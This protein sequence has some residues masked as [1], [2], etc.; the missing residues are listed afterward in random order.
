MTVCLVI[1]TLP[2]GGFIRLPLI[3]VPQQE[4]CEGLLLTLIKGFRSSRDAHCFPCRISGPWSRTPEG[5]P[6]RQML[7]AAPALGSL[8]VLTLGRLA[9]K[10]RVNIDHLGMNDDLLCP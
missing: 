6:P 2:G 1:L 8:P 9:I 7:W 4:G 10:A 5:V 3:G